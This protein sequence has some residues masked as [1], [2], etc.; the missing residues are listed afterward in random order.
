MGETRQENFKHITKSQTMQPMIIKQLMLS[1]FNYY[2]HR[3]KS[4]INGDWYRRGYYKQN[5]AWTLAAWDH[6]TLQLGI[7]KA[8]Q[9]LKDKRMLQS[10][11]EWAST[12][13]WSITKCDEFTANN[14]L[15]GEVYLLLSLVNPPKANISNIQ[16]ELDKV[17]AKPWQGN[18][19]WSW[20]DAIFMAPPAYAL[21]SK[22]SGNKKYLTFMHDKFLEAYNDFYDKED[23]LYF[24]DKNY[25]YNPNNPLTKAKN[26]KKIFWG[27]GNGWVIGGIA[28]I[29]EYM[30]KTDQHYPF[31]KQLFNEMAD[32]FLRT[33]QPSGLWSPSLLDPEDFSEKETTG[34]GLICYAL[35]WGINN[36]VLEAKTYQPVVEKSWMALCNCVMKNGA[37]GYVQPIGADPQHVD[38]LFTNDFG[39]GIFLLAGTEMLKLR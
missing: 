26:G 18:D 19:S 25:V 34:S 4:D 1:N 17:M 2:I 31:Y 20:C 16:N 3:M 29:M 33:Q 5:T 27:R 36:G 10:L 13:Q 32:K 8:Y 14:H 37:I 38:P 12:T 7:V 23:H 6:A 28:R 11:E 21:M 35:A 9:V 22:V 39:I 24:R 30:P 15:A